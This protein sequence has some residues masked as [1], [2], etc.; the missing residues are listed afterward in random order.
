[1]EPKLNKIKVIVPFY[2]P[3]DFLTTCINTL[4]TQDYGNY[5]VLFIDD[6]STDGSYEKIPACTYKTDDDGNPVSDEKGEP[7]IVDMHP[8]LKVTKC[9]NVL[10]WRSSE[11]VTA[12]SNIH[13]GIIN[14]CKDPD[15]IVILLDGDDWLI[16]KHVLSYVNDFYNQNEC[17]MMYGSSKWTDGRKCFSTPYPEVEFQNIRRAPYRIS[18][19]RSFR[20]GIYQEIGRQDPDFKCMQEVNGEGWYRTCYDVAMFLPMLEIAGFDKVKH[21]SKPLYIYNR[22]NPIS[23][24]K[25]SQENQTRVHRE[26]LT[27]PAF[28]K[29][30]SYKTEKE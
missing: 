26:V 2:N 6:C 27:K 28:K 1:M 16:N 12:L 5:E 3:G 20:A 19:L 14:F 15:D 29:V 7:I 25:V 10:A 17:W 4:L 23:D 11:R 9:L 8:I 21:N 22:D 30:E 13:N 18:H 24:D